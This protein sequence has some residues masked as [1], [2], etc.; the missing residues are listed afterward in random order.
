M[1][2]MAVV[3]QIHKSKLVLKP[4]PVWGTL[5]LEQTYES[6]N[7]QCRHFFPVHFANVPQRW[8]VPAA[9]EKQSSGSIN[10]GNDFGQWSQRP[11]GIVCEKLRR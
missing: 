1:I 10:R 6:H 5:S 9:K 3:A 8:Y 2:T 7:L 11:T 4:V